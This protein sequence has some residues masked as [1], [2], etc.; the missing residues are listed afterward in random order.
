MAEGS[1][2]PAGGPASSG[3][4]EPP[5]DPA[6]L[7]RLL[8]WLSPAFPVGGFSYSHGLEWAVEDGTVRDAATLR[9]WVEGVLH[10]GAGRTDAIFLAE[11]WRAAEAGDDARLSAVAELAAAFQPT[12]E[13]MLESTAQGRAFL[14]AVAAAWPSPQL[15]RIA[16]LFPAD[17]PLAYPVAVGAAAA[18]ENVPLR[19]T[20]T[21]F[22][23]AFAANLVSAGVRAIPVGQSDGLR[24]VAALAPLVGEISG[25]ALASGLA[26][27]G[28]MAFRAD[29]A[30]MKHETQYTRLFRS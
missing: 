7:Q 19:S 18:V 30:S 20:L 10:H 5:L 6:A 28:G 11:A 2:T 13:R 22:L 26:D 15:D 14:A 27:I 17:R 25:A 3:P 21:A 24:A 29:I 16:A 12:R 8:T 4:A 9:A 1:F 23:T